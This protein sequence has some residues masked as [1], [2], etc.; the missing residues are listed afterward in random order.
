MIGIDTNVLLR[1]MLEDDSVQSAQ[2]AQFFHD[3]AR[4]T[5]PALVNAVVLVE[6]VW[7]LGRKEGF[8]KA[9]ILEALD[10]LLGSDRIVLSEATCV[11]AAVTAW[12]G[13]PADFSDYL[14]EAL[15]RT[16]GATATL[17]FDKNASA[18]AGFSLIR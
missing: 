8:D 14:I 17:T 1:Y 4:V 18:A 7:T 9:R 3:P 16:S 15:N 12:R 11:Q 5:D 13:G 10:V 2:A 6:F